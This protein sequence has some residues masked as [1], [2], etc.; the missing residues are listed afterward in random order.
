MRIPYLAR[1]S[2]RP[3]NTTENIFMQFVTKVSY[4]KAFRHCMDH[5]NVVMLHMIGWSDAY[6]LS[7]PEIAYSNICR[8]MSATFKSAF[9]LNQ[10]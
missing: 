9:L 8:E 10:K 6:L 7:G 2:F 3:F 5:V 1:P 4:Y